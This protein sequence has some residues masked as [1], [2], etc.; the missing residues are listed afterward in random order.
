MVFL[1]LS[2]TSSCV[3]RQC[4]ATQADGESSQEMHYSSMNGIST[5][6]YYNVIEFCV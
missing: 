3:C 1:F 4:S 2:L 6:Y 5:H